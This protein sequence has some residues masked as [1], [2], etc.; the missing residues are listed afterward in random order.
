MERDC[1]YRE[2]RELSEV[3]VRIKIFFS[4]LR[5]DESVTGKVFPK[6]KKIK[7]DTRVFLLAKKDCVW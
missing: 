1:V 7:R 2:K 4:V 5:V 6:R 3:A